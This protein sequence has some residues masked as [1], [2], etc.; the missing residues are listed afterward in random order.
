MLILGVSIAATRG[1]IAAEAMA[2]PED[3]APAGPIVL[4]GRW[5][6]PHFGYGAR[7]VETDCGPGACALTFDIVACGS[8]W[9]G[10][11]VGKDDAC[12][13]I[14]MKLT[15][16]TEPDRANSFAGKLELAKGAAP[17]VV[18]AWYQAPGAQ[19]GEEADQARLSMVG[20]TGPEL[21]MY[22]RSFPFSAELARSGEA[23]C[24]LEKATS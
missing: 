16:N 8:E 18:E 20:D 9:C 5:V 23:K 11:A 7:A 19:A 13:A 12:G 4:A 1:A 24:T 2:S 22:R 6:G 15:H 10:I 14:A 21:M 3:P 17:Y